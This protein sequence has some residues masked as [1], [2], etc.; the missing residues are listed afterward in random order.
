MTQVTRLLLLILFILAASASQAK[1]T[2]LTISTL[3][4]KWY[5]LGGFMWNAPEMEFRQDN[6]KKFLSQELSDSDIIVFSE[7]VRNE[8]LLDLVS[9]TMDCALYDG[10][11]ER[12]QHISIC[13][14]RNKLRAEKYDE[15]FVIQEVDLG[16]TGFQRP[17]IQAKICLKRGPCLLQV[18]GVHLAAGLNSEKR[19]EQVQFIHANLIRQRKMLPTV[20][21]GD[22]NS[23][24]K[25][26][27]GLEEDDMTTFE[28]ILSAGTRRFRSVTGHITTYN[29]G[30]RARAYDH[31][32]TTSDIR[33]LS[34]RGYEACSR[35]PNFNKKFIPF[36]SFRKHFTDHCPV[37]AKIAIRH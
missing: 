18:I 32:V 34:T 5:G 3:N 6:F 30:D 24:I 21:T 15:D 31:I 17:A 1:T 33:T 4:L 25:Q 35:K 9:D 7:V 16:S 8:D 10:G 11:R 29:S 22:F 19:A 2:Q 20:I 28:K 36:S 13:Y 14:D 37:T 27:S 12:H 23:Y 26:Q